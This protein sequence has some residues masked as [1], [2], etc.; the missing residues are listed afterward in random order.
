MSDELCGSWN[1]TLA[2]RC[3]LKRGHK[4]PTH[5]TEYFGQKLS[6]EPEDFPEQMAIDRERRK[7]RRSKTIATLRTEVSRLTQ[8]LGEVEGE[9]DEWKSLVMTQ[10]GR[11]HEFLKDEATA[12][13]RTSADLRETLER[14][15]AAEPRLAE[16]RGLL[17]RLVGDRDEVP[18][19]QA[20]YVVETEARNSNETWRRDTLMAHAGLLRA[21]EQEAVA[22]LAGGESQPGGDG[23]AK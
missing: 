19:A 11:A 8:R 12:H 17:R 16:A 22:F 4:D 15:I 10:A 7:A 20:A 5:V 6:W 18:L 21:L 23:A 1:P 9:R 2:L 13:E 3:I 14:A